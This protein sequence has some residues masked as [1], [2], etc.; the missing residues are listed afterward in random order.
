MLAM[1]NGYNGQGFI[2]YQHRVV[3]MDGNKIGN[4]GLRF[5]KEYVLVCMGG[6]SQLRTLSLYDTELEGLDA[7]KELKD[8]I[9]SLHKIEFLNIQSNI[10]YQLDVLAFKNHCAKVFSDQLRPQ[11]L[12]ILS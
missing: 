9:T 3:E 10:I 1:Q 5:F 2:K 8:L 12:K 11:K 7:L 4:D 6:N